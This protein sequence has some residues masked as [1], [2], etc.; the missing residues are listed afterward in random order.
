MTKDIKQYQTQ[1]V[2][3]TKSTLWQQSDSYE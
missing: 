3:N 1:K 2:S